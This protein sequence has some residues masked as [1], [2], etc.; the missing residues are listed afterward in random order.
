M[1]YPKKSNKPSAENVDA[2]FLEPR[3][4]T[5]KEI[6]VKCQ[7]IDYPSLTVNNAKTSITLID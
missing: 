2:L 6:V 4:H 5:F 7:D 1:A 3:L